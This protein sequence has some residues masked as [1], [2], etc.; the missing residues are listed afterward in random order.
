MWEDSHSRSEYEV[1]GRD[2]Q[3]ALFHQSGGALVD[4][5]SAKTSLLSVFRKKHV[6]CAQSVHLS[7]PNIGEGLNERTIHQGRNELAVTTLMCADG[8]DVNMAAIF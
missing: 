2:D 3:T 7:A 5:I 4:K 1:A 8:T 6:D